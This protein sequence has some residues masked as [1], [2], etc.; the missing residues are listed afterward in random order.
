MYTAAAASLRS[1]DLSRQVGAAIFS[2]DGEIISL[3][4]NEVPKAFG[5][6]YW[7][8]DPTEKFRDFE[9]KTD[10]NQNRKYEILND[11]LKSLISNGI[12]IENENINQ[13]Y[14]LEKITEFD[15]LNGAQIM[16]IIE[17]GRIIHAEM[18]AITD[19]ARM[20]R[21][22]KDSY[23]FCTTFPCHMC[24]KHIVSSGV[25]KV[26]FLEPYPKSYAKELHDD[27]ITFLDS[28]D[29]KKVLFQPF[30]GISPRRYRDI[31][32]KKKRKDKVGKAQTVQRR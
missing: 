16:D 1:I 21:S 3:G 7:D 18:C 2:Q 10:P 24:A 14:I 19:A 29:N 15:I 11:L 22:T 32:E 28:E 13:N 4:C 30:I 6:T 26:F 27:S 20:G 25:K 9:K 12:I 8:D 23:L 31:F 5:G 17:F